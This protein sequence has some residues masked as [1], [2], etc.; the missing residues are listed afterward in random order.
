M[1]AIDTN[2]LLRYLLSD[3]S[4]QTAKAR[5]LIAANTVLVTDIVLAETM[6]VL[7]GRRYRVSRSDLASVLAA[8]IEDA[9]IYFEDAAVVWRAYQDFISTGADFQDALIMHKA[10]ALS[11]PAE[12]PFYTYDKRAAQ[13][14]CAKLL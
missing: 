5:E 12:M 14:A 2:V 1:I 7:Q 10:C 6:W 4:K 3:D 9:C 11:T 8:L 13:L